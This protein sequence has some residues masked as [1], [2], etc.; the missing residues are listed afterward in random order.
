MGVFLEAPW[1]N[2]KSSSF[3]DLIKGCGD[4][5]SVDPRWLKVPFADMLSTVS[6]GG[7]PWTWDRKLVSLGGLVPS[8][9]G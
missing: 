8:A 3:I 9:P 1:D 5:P 6:W 4:C 7:M 2:L